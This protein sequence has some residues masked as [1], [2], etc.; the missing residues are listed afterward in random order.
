MKT[1]LL[2][3]LLLL[4]LRTVFAVKVASGAF[5]NQNG[6]IIQVESAQK[7][8]KMSPRLGLS[9]LCNDG[10]IVLASY[11][12]DDDARKTL[13]T[14]STRIDDEVDVNWLHGDRFELISLDS[15]RFIV[16]LFGIPADCRLVLR[17]LRDEIVSCRSRFGATAMVSLK[18]LSESLS[19]YM[20]EL[21][22]SHDTRPL[23][24]EVLL[25]GPC[26]SAVVDAINV[27]DCGEENSTT[28]NLAIARI[29]CSGAY[30]FYRACCSMP[31]SSDEQMRVEDFLQS[32]DW[33]SMTS[34]DAERKIRD[35]LCGQGYNNTLRLDTDG[36][37][38]SNIV[39][40]AATTTTTTIGATSGD[41]STRRVSD[42]P[43]FV[44][45]SVR[46]K[47][48]LKK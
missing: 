15:G 29:D 40:T 35:F 18:E 1:S 16:S 37:I 43:H 2:E 26:E 13:Q 28:C 14:K 20:H 19:T 22:L 5:G 17:L 9:V 46:A 48:L 33:M 4:V 45:H 27:T 38:H 21:T 11:N 44:Y 39:A 36:L 34:I 8:I 10:A 3:L 12:A 30:D 24:V 31:S 47:R 32:E 23:A 41:S 6:K 42:G 7:A 25:V